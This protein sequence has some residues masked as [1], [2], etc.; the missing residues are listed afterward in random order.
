M[1]NI[2]LS[3]IA[4]LLLARVVLQ[5][6]QGKRLLEHSFCSTSDVENIEAVVDSY[7]VS[8]T[9]SRYGERGYEFVQA[10]CPYGGSGAGKTQLFFTKKR[11]KNYYE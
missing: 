1:T 7:S 11:I 3:I 2:L 5:V 10:I 6:K 4:I 9:I 8:T